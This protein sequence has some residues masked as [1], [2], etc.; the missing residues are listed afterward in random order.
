M[1]G[2]LNKRFRRCQRDAIEPKGS[3]RT[4]PFVVQVKELNQ[5]NTKMRFMIL[6]KGT[7]ASEGAVATHVRAR[8][9]Y[10]IAFPMAYLVLAVASLVVLL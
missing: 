3:E 1:G 9:F 6:V 8:V 10:S 4:F 7:K 2:L 5:G